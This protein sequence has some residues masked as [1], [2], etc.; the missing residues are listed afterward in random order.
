MVY[1][2]LCSSDKMEEWNKAKR[3]YD[4]SDCDSAVGSTIFS[5]V[6]S[7]FTEVNYHGM[8]KESS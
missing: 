5:T 3:K 1:V 4:E 6:K 2:L 7:Q 8:I